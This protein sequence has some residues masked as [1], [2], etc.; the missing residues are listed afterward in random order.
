[1]QSVFSPLGLPNLTHHTH[2]ILF[3]LSTINPNSFIQKYRKASAKKKD[4]YVRKYASELF[5]TTDHQPF[6]VL[7]NDVE[8]E[9]SRPAVLPKQ[10]NNLQVAGLYSF[11]ACSAVSSC[12]TCPPGHAELVRT[13]S[14]TV[15]VGGF[16]WRGF[17]YYKKKNV[18]GPEL[19]A[20]TVPR[21]S[22]GAVMFGFR[23]HVWFSRQPPRRLSADG[24]LQNG[25]NQLLL[26]KASFCL[27][28][29]AEG[30][31]RRN[32]PGL[33]QHCR[34]MVKHRGAPTVRY[35]LYVFTQG[36]IKIGAFPGGECKCAVWAAI[37]DRLSIVDS[38][39]LLSRIQGSPTKEMRLSLHGDFYFLFLLQLPPRCS[40]GI[41]NAPPTHPPSVG[42]TPWCEWHRCEHLCLP[43]VSAC[44]SVCLSVSCRERGGIHALPDL[45]HSQL[46]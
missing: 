23:R 19:Y 21:P 24:R 43:K 18:S 4:L 32:Q 41:T 26:L 31:S 35:S 29:G 13:Q 20:S 45:Y 1:M 16:L 9:T 28:R 30:G 33:R 17:R 7:T 14:A 34:C 27:R 25:I 6:K 37:T 10:N 15:F 42:R 5:I 39:P 36:Q 40:S 44:L 2:E 46:L 8:V 22:P 11:V 38:N 12:P 3:P